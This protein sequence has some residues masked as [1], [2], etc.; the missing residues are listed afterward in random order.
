[1]SKMGALKAVNKQPRVDKDPKLDYSAPIY[2]PHSLPLYKERPTNN[3]KKDLLEIRK[4]PTKSE[5]PIFP[6]QGPHKNGRQNDK[7]YNYIQHMIQ[8]LASN[9]EKVEDA[10][11]PLWELQKYVKEKQ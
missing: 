9:P 10:R 1:M 8:S 7:A 11:K 3:I 2:L 4:D 6:Q 5:R